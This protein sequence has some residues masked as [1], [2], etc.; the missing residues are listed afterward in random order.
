MLEVKNPKNICI[1]NIPNEDPISSAEFK[2][3]SNLAEERK[4]TYADSGNQTVIRHIYTKM[5]TQNTQPL[6]TRIKNN[7]LT[8]LLKND[9]SICKN[10]VGNPPTTTANKITKILYILENPLQRL[11]RI[12]TT[13][14]DI[15]GDKDI[16]EGVINKRNAK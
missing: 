12:Q 16:F 7:T 5:S 14:D 8:R 9:R 13:N 1:N 10:I 6:I 4:Y 3:T 15:D 2:R 11:P